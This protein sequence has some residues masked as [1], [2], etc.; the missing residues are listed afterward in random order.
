MP[1][2]ESLDRNGDGQLSIT[3]AQSS[4]SLAMNFSTIDKLGRGYITKSEY[5]AYK[6]KS[7]VPQS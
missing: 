2:F 3:E 6:A 7:S 4:R 5:D 1:T